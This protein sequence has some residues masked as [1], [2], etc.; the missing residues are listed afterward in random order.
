[1]QARIRHQFDGGDL[2]KLEPPRDR[3]HRP[4]RR[5]MGVDSGAGQWP[6]PVRLIHHLACTGGTLISRCIAAQPD[7]WVLSEVDP[8]SPFVPGR[9]LPTDLIGLSRFGSPPADTE[10]QIELFLA[11]L[12]VLYAQ[13]RRQGEHLVLREHSHGQF[14]FG[15][16]VAERPTLRAIV[17]R[18]Y[19]TRALV[20]VRHPFDTFL[21]LQD[22]GWVQHFSPPTLD[23]YARRVHAFLD[24]HAG[25][26][27]IRYEDF[28]ADPAATMQRI[29]EGLGLGYNPDFIESF[30]AIELS[31]DS[32]RHG[33]RISPRPRR[34]HPPTLEQEACASEAFQTLLDRLDYRLD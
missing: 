5:A 34:A 13:A 32:G 22:T 3:R 1:M 23:E 18:V 27:L 17:G 6:P 10:T 8:L 21:S 26:P 31:G 15:E 9:F 2:P 25:C 16:A 28:V 19:P 11:G 4:A 12:A 29:C 33:D 24:A 14:H 7:T 20:T 30:S